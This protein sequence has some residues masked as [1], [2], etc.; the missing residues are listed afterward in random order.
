MR[1]GAVE[2]ILREKAE[3]GNVADA[4]VSHFLSL[5]S[6]QLQDFIH[7]RKFTNATFHKTQLPGTD[8]KL[9]KTRYQSQTAE[10]IES[11]CS[12]E[13]T[14]LVWLAWKLRS[15]PLVMKPLELPILD[16]SVATPSFSV[17]Y[18]Q[19][20]STKLPSDY[21]QND[22]WIESLKSVLK[23][24]SFVALTSQLKENANQL[25]IIL[26]SRF[27]FHVES[28]VDTRRQDH[29]TIRFTRDNIPAVAAAMCV[30]GHI[31]DDVSKWR[32]DE[33]LLNLPTQNN[34]QMLDGILSQL[35]GCYLYYD[36]HKSKWIRSGKTSGDGVDACFRGRGKNHE[37]NSKSLDQMRAHRLYREY[38]WPGV[39]HLGV[40]E[41]SFDNL[42][43]Y[44]GMAYDKRGDVTALCSNGSD[45]SLLAWSNEAITELKKKGGD[46][47]K[48][49]WWLFHICLK[50][51][52]M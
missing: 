21:L 5:N 40:K 24:V 31:V 28:K 9:N 33:R 8:G 43:M 32:D 6:K 14:C 13:E 4:T 41:G 48:Y 37:D 17:V 50:Y 30:V 26:E 16:T 10:S 44:C 12:N 20:V 42:A 1:N 52:T 38:P 46:L 29:W 34:F 25:A 36:Q 2:T 23:G 15:T 27:N 35:E 7:A 3:G 11:D 49:S 51:C 39:E 45:D 22:M 47:K 19:P 18:Y